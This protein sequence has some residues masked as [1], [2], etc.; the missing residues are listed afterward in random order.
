MELKLGLDIGISSVGWGII[1]ENYNIID[2]GVRL[3]S[4]GSAE[5]NLT[6]RTMRS[7]RRRVRR[8]HHRLQRMGILLAQILKID[9]PEPQGNIYEIRSRGLKEKLSREELFLAVM[10]LAK[11]RG[12]YFLTAEDI[13]EKNADGKSNEEILAE[14]EAKLTGKYVCEIQYERYLVDNGKVRGID[15]RFR[16]KDYL[17]ELEQLLTI[18][19][20]F[21]PEIAENKTAIMDI[22]NSKREYYEGPGSVKSPTPYG[23]Y[24]YDEDGNVI[25]VDLIDLM[26][27]R[28]T[29]FPDEKRIAKGAYTACLFNLLND[30]NN[31]KI[32]ERKLTAEEKRYFVK[33]FINNGKNITLKIIAKKV[34]KNESEIT[35][36]RIDKNNKPLF[37]EFKQYKNI[38]KVYQAAGKD[39]TELTIGLCDNIADVLT[40]VKSVEERETELVSCK[41]DQ[42]VAHELAKAAGFTEYH[43]LSKKAMDLIIEDLWETDK[44]QMQLFHEAGMTKCN[45]R[46]Y[47]GEDIKFDGSDWIVSPITKRAVSE[48]VKVINA[49]RKF[50][51]RKYKQEFSDIVI[52]MAREKNSAE[53][54][55]NKQKVQKINE[56]RGNAVRELTF[57]KKITPRQFEIISLL[58][59]QDMKC[60]YSG[61]PVSLT[62]VYENMLEVDH[63]IPRSLSFDD[64]RNNKVAVFVSENQKKGQRTPF[65]YLSSGEGYIAYEV[66]KRKVLDNKAYSQRKKANLL[67]ENAPEKE[68]RGFINRNLVDT[69]YACR[70]VLNMLQNYFKVN[71]INTRVKVVNG[72]FTF[73]FRKK[74][75]LSKDR[76]STYAHHAQD[77]LI[78]A[79]LFNTALIKKLNSIITMS[80]SFL[81]EKE[82]IMFENGKVVNTVTGE[83]ISEDDFAANKYI[84]FIKQIELR[85]Q[86]YSHKVDRK[87]N[88]QLYDQQIK[89]TRICLDSKGKEETF[90]VTKYKN[91]YAVGVGSCGD[92]LKKRILENPESLLIY[93]NDQET[94]KKFRE[95]V[96]F[97]SDAK[98]PF[99]EYFKEHGPIKKYA[100]K[101]DGPEIYDIKFLDGRLGVHRVNTRQN[102]KNKSVYLQ[103]KSLRVDIYQD[104]GKYKF[105]NVPYDM[106][107]FTAGIYKI[108]LEKYLQSK[109]NKKIT[110]KAEFLFS[111]Y[112]GEFFSYEKDGEIYWWQFSCLNND[113]ANKLEAKYIEKPSPGATQGERTITIG[114]KIKNM[115]KYHVDVLGNIYPAAKETLKT[116]IEL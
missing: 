113:R 73:A 62:E 54:K 77:A 74:A 26:R 33:E 16:N 112:R 53:E 27:G 76:D 2:S 89:S 57:G 5:E 52:E 31:L 15:N 68:L 11:R 98:N 114:A 43:S 6:R 45:E 81:D 82:A 60:A 61:K 55:Q 51:R 96:D 30:F 18:Q 49:A 56:E 100:K 66:F 106:L 29:F 99:A 72:S 88:R 40:R 116:E 34:V 109:A 3:F 12:T 87:P 70:E 23:R 48:S 24:R 64:S 13:E 42:V 46:D 39:T 94:F 50:V 110:S 36:Y 47:I 7:S 69:R 58:K 92:K 10:H 84:Q 83:F 103:I 78:I 1:D 21:Y 67:Y 14:Q 20:K 63:I 104:E 101:D 9:L 97:Y 35:G 8:M 115:L 71:E 41:I 95:I 107:K 86:K 25:K 111:L 65:Q 90:V 28:C 44:N 105:V 93:R 108:D 75:K 22:Y 91:I 102:G 4:E 37:T 32:G 59:D 19:S 85:P 38:L 80:D 79:G 17:R